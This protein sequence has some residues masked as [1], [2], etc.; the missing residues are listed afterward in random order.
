MEA[1]D[2][3]FVMLDRVQ[4]NRVRQIRKLG[5]NATKLVNRH[6]VFFELEIRDPLLQTPHENIVRKLVLVGEACS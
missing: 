3:V 1:S 2:V 6:F 5:V 4:G